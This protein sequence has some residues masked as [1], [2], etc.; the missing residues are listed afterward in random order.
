M[1]RMENSGV[2]DRNRDFV[3]LVAAG[4]LAAQAVGAAIWWTVLFAW[5]VSRAHFSSP[6][7]STGTLMSFLVA[8][9]L[10]YIGGSA[11]AAVGFWLNKQ[12]A[13]PVLCVHAGA[14]SYAGL[15][16]WNLFAL[17]GHNLA[18]AVLMTPS[19]IVPWW[20]IYVLNPLE[21]AGGETK[22]GRHDV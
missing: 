2:N 21:V 8:D 3:K 17:T 1:V 15:Y 20:L 6:E 22:K 7:D 11:L 19:M 9:F 5:P 14:A 16:C 10:L 13:W 18:G 12:W 4:Y